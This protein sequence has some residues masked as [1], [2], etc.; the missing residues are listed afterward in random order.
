[1]FCR[2][3]GKQLPDHAKFCSGCGTPVQRP[4][5]I[6]P[7]P[8][9]SPVSEPV[10]PKEPEP[11]IPPVSEPVLP[12]DP[13]PV[14]PP[15]SEP[16]LPKD[17]E[18]VIPPVSRPFDTAPM[19]DIYSTGAADPYAAPPQN[20][21]A[22]PQDPYVAPPQNSYAAPQN[23][24]AAPY[25]QAGYQGYAQPNPYT[26]PQGYSPYGQASGSHQGPPPFTPGQPA[27]QPEKKS[28]TALIIGIV[29]G[30]LLLA[31]VAVLLYFVLGGQKDEN[32]GASSGGS[33][34]GSSE[35][36]SLPPESSQD[37]AVIDPSFSQES[38]APS[39]E[40]SAVVPS[41][42]SVYDPN[43]P[44]LFTS[45]LGFACDYSTTGVEMVEMLEEVGYTCTWVGSDKIEATVED[46]RNL[47]GYEVRE[48]DV[49]LG[50][51]GCM[52]GCALFFY[53]FG[54]GSEDELVETI[55]EQFESMAVSY[56]KNLQKQNDDYG[57]YWMDDNGITKWFAQVIKETETEYGYL[58]C[59]I[60]EINWMDENL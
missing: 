33:L 36:S 32:S 30:V 5:V 13:E 46:G 17:P 21:Y 58:L 37:S 24:Y 59:A 11:V 31:A 3:C 49:Y 16:V 26:Q 15:V 12:K 22:A 4:A 18:P 55:G 45:F 8:T 56:G 43:A 19:P 23:P 57:W 2:N 29:A 40:S 1:M 20:S 14:I 10:L 48:V 27:P 42:G 6:P 60:G 35:E 44:T 52:L 34:F 39:S 47:N 54:E 41:S 53:D 7:E 28:H 50:D 38:L 9:I 25:T 51:D